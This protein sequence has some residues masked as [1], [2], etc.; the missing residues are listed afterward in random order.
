MAENPLDAVLSALSPSEEVPD[1]PVHPRVSVLSTARGLEP[2]FVVWRDPGGAR[3]LHGALRELV[4][5]TLLVHLCTV[6]EA[7]E[8]P[9][10]GLRLVMFAPVA[11]C[12]AAVAAF[13]FSRAALDDEARRAI[14]H[15]RGEAAALHRE[16]PDEAW[17]VYAAQAKST[18][19]AQRFEEALVPETAGMIFGAE[20][21]GLFARY[22]A[23]RRALGHA[24]LPASAEALDLLERELVA[25][26]EGVLRWI[27]PACFRALCDAVAVVAARAGA[28][29]AWAEGEPDERGIAPPPLV[30]LGA[31]DGAVHVPLGL[32][33]LRWCVMPRRQGETVPPLRAWVTDALLQG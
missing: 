7:P 5:A 25:D 23:V 30:R 20:P 14:V 6:I 9:L 32:E 21:G 19:D 15:A 26:E 11:D 17:A 3:A 13:G 28:P 16:V 18:S 31:D 10:A 2:L 24:D 8:P 1:L 27:P 29:I 4:E 33:L 22:A 12:D